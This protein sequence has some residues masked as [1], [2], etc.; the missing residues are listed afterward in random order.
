MQ[1]LR[2]DM[3]EFKQ[4]IQKGSLQRAY[5][6]LL[7]FMLHLKNHFSS[8][9]AEYPA[10]GALYTGYMDMTYFSILPGC[11]KE[12]QLKIALVFVYDAFRF[13]IW[14]SAKNKQVLAKTWNVIRDSGW[15]KYTVVEPGKGVDSVLKHVLVDDPDFGDWDSLTRQIEQVAVQ[16]IQDVEQWLLRDVPSPRLVLAGS[17]T[18]HAEAGQHGG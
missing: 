6:G 14:L 2:Q 1:S 9:Y 3:A 16:F 11:L 10:P 13:E 12:R 7:E 15:D 17:P 5:Q 8:R 4:Q 18:S